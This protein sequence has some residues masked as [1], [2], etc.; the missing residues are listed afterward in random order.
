MKL[1]SIDIETTGLDPETCQ[2]LEFA[3]VCFDPD[4]LIAVDGHVNEKGRRWTQFEGLIKHDVIVGDA[5]ALQMNQEILAE[6]SGAKETYRTIYPDAES[7]V[8]DFGVWLVEQGFG[9]ERE[10]R[11]FAVG[12]NYASF[13]LQF[14]K[15]IPGWSKL[16]FNHRTL[17]VGS[18]CF[19]PAD[20]R[21]RNLKDCL[22]V[23]GIRKEISHRAID[24][25]RD[26]ATVVT[27]FFA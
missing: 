14:L 26:V 6:I 20:G 13:D 25:A 23:L 3:A 24:D 22:E 4:P 10:N 7:L 9:P 1:V 27:R 8:I 12:K 5:Y 16:P 19:N 17:D 21:I 18:L 11:A 15:R 2:V